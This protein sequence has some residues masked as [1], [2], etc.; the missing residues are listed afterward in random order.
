MNYY[1]LHLQD[2]NLYEIW[3]NSNSPH[4]TCNDICPSKKA[5]DWKQGEKINSFL[6]LPP[7]SRSHPLCEEMG[8]LQQ[9]KASHVQPRRL[10]WFHSSDKWGGSVWIHQHFCGQC[11]EHTELEHFSTQ[12]GMKGGCNV[13]DG[14]RN[15]TNGGRGAMQGKTRKNDPSGVVLFFLWHPFSELFELLQHLFVRIHK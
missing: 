11:L 5:Y 7:P 10:L 15:W 1:M 9:M 12:S 4:T 2:H 13:T 3:I 6:K 14:Q 8:Q